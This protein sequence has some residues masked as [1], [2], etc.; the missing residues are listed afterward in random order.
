MG[1]ECCDISAFRKHGKNRIEVA[2]KCNSKEDWEKNW[3]PPKH[4]FF[5]EFGD[6]WKHSVQYAVDD[7]AAEVGFFIDGL[8]MTVNAFC[9]E[10]AM[11][12]SPDRDFFFSVVPSSEEHKRTDPDSITLEFTVKDICGTVKELCE[13]TICMDQD[14]KP[15]QEGSAMYSAVFQTPNGIKVRIWGMLDEKGKGCCCSC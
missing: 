2:K 7:F 3:E 9:E 14:P 12:T 10:Y 8:G 13:R 5:V 15:V 1:K 4:P 6:C 11:L